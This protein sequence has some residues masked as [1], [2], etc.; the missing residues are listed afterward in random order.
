MKVK[1]NTSTVHSHPPNGKGGANLRPKKMV[2]GEP[3]IGKWQVEGW[4]AQ[5]LCIY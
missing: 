5:N 3:Y 2:I 1:L 4:A